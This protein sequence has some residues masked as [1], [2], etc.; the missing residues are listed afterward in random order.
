MAAD[1]T[2]SE[3]AGRVVVIC[4]PLPNLSALI[5]PFS[6]FISRSASHRGLRQKERKKEKKIYL[7]FPHS[8][9]LMQSL[10]CT[11]YG[12]L[13]VNGQFPLL[14]ISLSLP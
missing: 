2:A 5:H 4:L 8:F 6:G 3:A 11:L 10:L 9:S 7:A 14:S 13:V 12:L 1:G